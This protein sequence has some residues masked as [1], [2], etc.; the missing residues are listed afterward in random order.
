MVIIMINEKEVSEELKDV[1]LNELYEVIKKILYR[2][3]LPRENSFLVKILI[4]KELIR[5][6]I[7]I[8][9]IGHPQKPY[10]ANINKLNYWQIAIILKQY[11]YIREPLK[12]II[13]PG[14]S[15]KI[16]KILTI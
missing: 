5:R 3:D 7:L 12:F 10:D 16:S 15:I 4:I 8:V 6:K 14:D 2:K 1:P 9:E 11:S 13:G